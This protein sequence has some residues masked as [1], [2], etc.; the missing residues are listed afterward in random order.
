MKKTTSRSVEQVAVNRLAMAVITGVLPPP[1]AASKEGSINEWRVAAA[2]AGGKGGAL[3][4]DSRTSPFSLLGRTRKCERVLVSVS[5]GRETVI[6][7]LTHCS[8]TRRT[9]YNRLVGVGID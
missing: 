6:E 2:L 4:G 7:G 3:N 8:N 5:R 9:T 1:T